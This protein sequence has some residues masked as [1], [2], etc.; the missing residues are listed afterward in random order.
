MP[1]VYAV[2]QLAR[3]TPWIL[4]RLARYYWRRACV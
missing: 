1:T 4:C 3:S 2:F